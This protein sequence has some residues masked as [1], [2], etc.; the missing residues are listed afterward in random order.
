MYATKTRNNTRNNFLEKYQLATK[1]VHSLTTEQVHSLLLDT[2]YLLTDL[3][4]NSYK[5][6]N[7]K[8]LKLII[9]LLITNTKKKHLRRT[10]YLNLLNPVLLYYLLS[11]I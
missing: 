5:I 8:K 4:R 10:Q 7:T 3:I 6:T 2:N 9:K 11:R 1:P